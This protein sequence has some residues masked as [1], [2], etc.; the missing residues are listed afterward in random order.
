MTALTELAAQ[1]LPAVDTRT[2]VCAI[3][4]P[5]NARRNAAIILCMQQDKQKAGNEK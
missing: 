4:V 2:P 3:A 1:P 5:L